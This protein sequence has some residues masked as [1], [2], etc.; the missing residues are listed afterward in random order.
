MFGKAVID[1]RGIERKEKI[2]RVK[3][4]AVFGGAEVILDKNTPVRIKADVVFGGVQ[5]PENV[6][7]GFGSASY[8]SPDFDE[9]KNC[10]FIDASSVFGGIEIH[11]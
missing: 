1:L 9:N 7:G 5:T 2:T 10:L 4:N 11:Y 3:I 8:Q 6:A